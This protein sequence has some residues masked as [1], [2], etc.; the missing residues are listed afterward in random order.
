MSLELF[1]N[2]CWLGT[3]IAAIGYWCVQA[4]HSDEKSIQGLRSFLALICALLVL[5]PV[6]SMTDDLYVCQMMTSPHQGDLTNLIEITKSKLVVF[7]V[8]VISSLMMLLF[9]RVIWL[10]RPQS[11]RTVASVIWVRELTN[12]P[13]PASSLSLRFA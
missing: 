10:I 2:L 6:I 3:A 11:L 8:A 5:F 12:R 9:A 4:K 13:P 7:A 1:L